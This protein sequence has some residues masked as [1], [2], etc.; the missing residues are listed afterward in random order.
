MSL[1][2]LFVGKVY[3]YKSYMYHKDKQVNFILLI[4][5]LSKQCTWK[6]VDGTKGHLLYITTCQ[7]SVM[8]IGSHPIRQYNKNTLRIDKFISKCK[9]K[10]ASF[11]AIYK[12]LVNM[13]IKIEDVITKACH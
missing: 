13:Q 11:Y 1:F 10:H 2:I 5:L 3:I 8:I 9:K 7:D 6:T 4:K 12:S